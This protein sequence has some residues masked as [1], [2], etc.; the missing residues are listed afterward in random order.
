[1]C[2]VKNLIL[3]N[4]KNNINN[5]ENIRQKIFKKEKKYLKQLTSI[6]E[7]KQLIKKLHLDIY[8]YF[9]N[10]KFL[11]LKFKELK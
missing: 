1:M 11:I 9:V 3:K 8:S 6:K 2:L 4:N 10:T 5:K 7:K